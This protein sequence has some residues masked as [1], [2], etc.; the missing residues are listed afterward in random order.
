MRVCVC[1]RHPE[2]EQY[3]WESQAGSTSTIKCTSETNVLMRV[4]ACVQHPDDEQ[5]VWESQAGG[6]FTIARDTAGPPLG[7]GTK[8]RKKTACTQDLSSKPGNTTLLRTMI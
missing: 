8:A 3:M 1:V 2:D 6:T 4:C 5:Y 7:R